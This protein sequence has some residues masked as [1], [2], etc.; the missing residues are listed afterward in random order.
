MNMFHDTYSELEHA[1]MKSIL[2]YNK[3]YLDCVQDHTSLF[4]YK[5]KITMQ[6]FNMRVTALFYHFF[7]INVY[8]I[9]SSQVNNYISNLNLAIFLN[10]IKKIQQY[11]F[12]II[13]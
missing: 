5:K 6:T 9:N 10:K 12:I 13:K 7:L 2:Y 4:Y 3:N 8:A 1:V 11:I